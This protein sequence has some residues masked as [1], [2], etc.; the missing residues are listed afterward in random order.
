[1]EFLV[2]E[3]NDFNDYYPGFSVEEVYGKEDSQIFTRKK[4][5]R[6]GG[7]GGTAQ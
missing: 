6:G 5:N 4:N 7:A 3:Y 2:H 1:M